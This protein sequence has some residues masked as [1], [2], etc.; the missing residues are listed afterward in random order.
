MY[1]YTTREVIVLVSFSHHR[2]II[3]DRNVWGNTY[4]G[5]ECQTVNLCS[6][7]SISKPIMGLNTVALGAYV[8]GYSSL[9]LWL[10]SRK[11][12]YTKGPGRHV[13]PRAYPQ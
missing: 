4:F 7:D 5:L 9:F 11:I 13:A 2:D 10:E 1:K 12:G 3:S 8:V 6:L